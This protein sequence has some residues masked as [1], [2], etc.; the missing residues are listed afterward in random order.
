M[1]DKGDSI[2]DFPSSI[3]ILSTITLPSGTDWYVQTR[4][5]CLSLT[6]VVTTTTTT[7]TSIPVNG[8]LMQ[9]EGNTGKYAG[10]E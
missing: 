10:G 5:K 6:M 2:Q 9:L 4:S 7:T 1:H 8:I 3:T